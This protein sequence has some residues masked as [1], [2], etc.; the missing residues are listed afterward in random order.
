MSELGKGTPFGLTQLIGHMLSQ[1]RVTMKTTKNVLSSG[2]TMSH[3]R[4][5]LWSNI[6][7]Q[8]TLEIHNFKEGRL[9]HTWT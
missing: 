5:P 1:Y 9:C 7:E 3:T 8:G 4:M 6:P 2:L